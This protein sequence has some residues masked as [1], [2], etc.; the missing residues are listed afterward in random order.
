MKPPHTRKLRVL[1]AVALAAAATFKGSDRARL[2]RLAYTAAEA[3]VPL[4][5]VNDVLYH[6]PT[7]RILQEVVSCV[8]ER[9]TIDQLGFKRE[10]Y[11]DRHLALTVHGRC[12]P[13]QAGS[14]LYLAEVRQGDG[15]ALR[16][17]SDHDR[18]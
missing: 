18:P 10:R 3:G 2:N 11:A 16:R 13:S 12:A 8:R 15:Y 6:E 17:R 7:R 14:E 5:A 4:L 1:A 9:C